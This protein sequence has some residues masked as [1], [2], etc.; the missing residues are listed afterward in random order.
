MTVLDLDLFECIW[1]D[2]PTGLWISDEF[3]NLTACNHSLVTM[4]GVTELELL[5]EG[6]QKF[7]HAED[8]ART[9]ELFLDT[10]ENH[11]A[12]VLSFR[13]RHPNAVRHLEA[14]M[15]PVFEK[16]EFAG[17]IGVV[18][19]ITDQE[20]AERHLRDARKELLEKEKLATIGQTTAVVAHELRN[21]L[22]TI[23]NSLYVLDRMSNSPEQQDLIDRAVRSILRCD[24][25]INELLDFTRTTEHKMEYVDPNAL[26]QSLVQE[27]EAV[28]HVKFRTEFCEIEKIRIVKSKI[29]RAVLN[30]IQNAIEAIE[31]CPDIEEGAILI[32]TMVRNGRFWIMIANNG[33][34][35]EEQYLE[36]IFEP[37][38]STKGFGVGLGLP[39]CRKVFEEHGGGLKARNLKDGVVFAGWFRLEQEHTG[40]GSDH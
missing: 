7:I 22:G 29:E 37:L 12:V 20:N 17:H 18:L 31:G 9:I 5:D 26:I 24:G 14:R 3:G 10:I 19:D 25:I 30:I 8:Q 40:H 39:V 23:R 21:P 33:P 36:K 2:I 11:E 16:N 28:E 6:W 32:R 13:V 4:M 38:F 35:I 1:N 34:H 15:K 27:Y